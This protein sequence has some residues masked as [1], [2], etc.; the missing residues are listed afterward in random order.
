MS[1]KRSGTSFEKRQRERRKERRRL[2]KMENRR[3]RKQDNPFEDDE[4]EET[5][6]R[7]PRKGEPGY[8]ASTKRAFLTTPTDGHTHLLSDEVGPDMRGAS[9]QTS[10]EDG[11]SHPWIMNTDTGAITIGMVAST[12]NNSSWSSRK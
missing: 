1:R 11:H 9:G 5:E 7:K 8:R 3:Q 12:E 2:E 6:K 4:E 10:F